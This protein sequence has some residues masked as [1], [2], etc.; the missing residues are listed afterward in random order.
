M[1]MFEVIQKGDTYYVC[2]RGDETPQR[3]LDY[4]NKESADEWC[5]RLNEVEDSLIDREV[6]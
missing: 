5:D 2:R 4:A 3:G 6:A 1:G